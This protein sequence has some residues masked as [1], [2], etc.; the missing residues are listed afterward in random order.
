LPTMPK[1]ERVSYKY[2]K[3]CSWEVFENIISKI[4]D[5][6]TREAIITMRLQWLR[7]GE[8]RGLI[9]ETV[10]FDSNQ[11]VIKNSFSGN[12][13]RETTKTGNQATIHLHST[14]KDMLWPRR[15]H[16]KAFVFTHRGRPLSESWL[17]KRF[18]EAR[19]KVGYS[20]ELCLYG[21]TRHSSAT[22]GYAYSKDIYAVK[23][24]LRHEDIR[25]TLK[26]THSEETQSI[27]EPSGKVIQVKPNNKEV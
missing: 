3:V 10:L 16:P 23:K 20:K 6:L 12:E 7:T 8:V 1:W 22:E 17:R 27:I 21:A 26:Y 25:T 18:N 9:W 19:D 14:V 11:L 24:A 2:R 5:E 13:F 15:G 4:P